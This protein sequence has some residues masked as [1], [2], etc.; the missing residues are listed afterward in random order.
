MK[1]R[2]IPG[3]CGAAVALYTAACGSTQVGLA[4]APATPAPALTNTR[5]GPLS[6]ADIKLMTLVR[7]TSLREIPVGLQRSRNPQVRSAA[8]MI[9]TQ[10]VTLQQEDLTAAATP[11]S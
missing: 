8:Q 7:E 9:I 11:R 6:A 2:A 1:A 4:A 5:Y 3:A 10:H